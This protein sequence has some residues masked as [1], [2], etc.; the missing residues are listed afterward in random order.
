MRKTYP[1]SAMQKRMLTNPP[2][3]KH[4]LTGREIETVK[5]LATMVVFL[6]LKN[7]NGFWFH[8]HHV[9]GDILV[10]Y[11]LVNNH[12]HFCPVRFTNILSYF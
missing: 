4:C 5:N 7:G 6:W 3:A 10:G 12:W 8:L 9:D 11:R 2:K 1:A